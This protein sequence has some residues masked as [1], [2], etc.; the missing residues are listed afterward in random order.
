[1]TISHFI[2]V[3][4]F[5]LAWWSFILAQVPFKVTKPDIP[6]SLSSGFHFDD[7][8][9]RHLNQMRRFEHAKSCY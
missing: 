5:T 9:V 1:M 4:F 8:R 2:T 3:H 6:G 7:Y